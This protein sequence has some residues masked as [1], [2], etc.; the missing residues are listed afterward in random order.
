[1]HSKVVSLAAP[2]SKGC[3]RRRRGG[4][5]TVADDGIG[6]RDRARCLDDALRDRVR[7]TNRRNADEL[8]RQPES[9]DYR[10]RLG[11][12]AHSSLEK[13]DTVTMRWR[14]R[15]PRTR[16]F[17]G[18]A[19]SCPRTWM[20]SRGSASTAFPQAR[21]T[22]IASKCEQAARAVPTVIRDFRNSAVYGPLVI[23]P[24]EPSPFKYD[25]EHVVML[26]DWTDENPARVF[27]KLKKRSDY[28]NFHQRTVGDFFR[29]VRAQGLKQ[30]LAD[31]KMWGEM[32]MNPTDLADV[33]GHTYTYLMNG[34]APAGNWT[35]LF[36]SGERVRLR[37]IN[38]SAM[39]YFDVRIPGLKMTVVAADGQYV[40]RS[41]RRIPDRDGGNLRRHR[42]TLRPGRI[43]DLRA[44]HGSNGLRRGRWPCVR[45]CERRCPSSTPGRC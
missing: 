45:A 33:S 25:R 9:R 8:H 2:S 37:F 24:L 23:E 17:T 1:M 21:P 11:S 19:F 35:G 3:G 13:G 41:R 15:S 40:H 29:D 12:G 34:T 43:H 39:S 7:P 31:R 5:W 27:A 38:G 10:E 20:A 30:A 16:P 32:R 18:T 14:T 6:A 22:C 4:T 36:K 42:R 44:V 26:T 28:Y